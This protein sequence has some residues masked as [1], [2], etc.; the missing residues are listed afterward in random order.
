MQRLS[1]ILLA[2]AALSGC[3][4]GGGP[5]PAPTPTPSPAPA[6][7]A[8][9][10]TSPGT[11]SLA[12]N[13]TLA[14]QAVV[15]D[16]NGDPLSL[17]IA[18]GADAALFALDMMGRLS[19]V[20]P[21]NYDQPQD[22]NGDNVHEVS[23][24]VSDGKASTSLDLRVTVTNS[25]EGVAVRRVA[26]GFAQ[27]V[28][29]YRVEGSPGQ[30]YLAEKGGRIYQL[31]TATGARTLLLTI[32]GLSTDGERGLI[33]LAVGRAG[34]GTS[35]SGP[36]IYTLETDSAG[37][38]NLRW[39]PRNPSGAFVPSA[40]QPVLLSIPHPSYNNHNGGWIDFG[41]GGD[42]PGAMLYLG[43][44]DGGSAGDPNNN[45]QNPGSRLGKL[46]R[47]ARSPDP[48]AGAAPAFWVAAPGNP[49]ASGGGDPFVYALG[50]RNP[51]RA[52][53]EGNDI[54]IGDVG[55]GAIEEIDIIA[56]ASSG[57]NLGWPYLEGTQSYKGGAPPG[58]VAP[59]LQYRHGNGRYDG[60]SVIG[61]RVYRGPIASLDGKY[62]FADYVSRHIWAVPY[63]RLK[64][65]PLLDGAGY[66][67]R[68]ADFV[69]DA[70][71]I[72][73]PVAFGTDSAGTLFIVDLDGEIYRV[74]FDPATG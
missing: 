50:L 69:P 8:P 72:D 49:F 6:N 18:G 51:F 33:G 27:P 41:P 61:G 29:V 9:V 40:D 55:Q 60:A 63:A 35:G 19:F 3:G 59:L 1:L 31:D 36:A 34:P 16:A 45:A 57:L 12:E 66:E 4:E 24:R 43:I 53:F 15:S 73:A 11:A 52:A 48:Y 30:L 74:D 38:I 2:C 56:A 42:G 44:G 39:Y 13:G 62:L 47:L 28:Q 5:A 22:A 70:G 7:S 67:Q 71:A 32:P 23:L 10:F 17:T 46:L 64:A 21:P 54:V 58:L 65:G 20:A 37:T 25:K 68:D 26:T 14:Y